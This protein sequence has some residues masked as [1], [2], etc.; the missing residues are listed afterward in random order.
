M[1]FRN[2]VYEGVR[3]VVVDHVGSGSITVEPG[4]RPDLVDCSINAADERFLDEIQV[5][6]DQDYLRITFPPPVGRSTHAHLRLGVPDGLSFVVKAGAADVTIGPAIA[7][8]R[9]VCRSGDITVGC[10]TDLDCST[11]S[12]AI[13]IAR[14]QGSAA[15]IS[16]GSGDVSIGDAFCTTSAKSGSG[17]VVVRSLHSGDLRANSGSGDIAVT[18]T[19]GSVDLRT[20]S[21]SLTVGIADHLPAWLDL[22]SGT[23]DIRIAV[24]SSAPPAPGEPYVSVRGRTGSGDIAVY[25]A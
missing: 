18:S 17:D 13:S 20:A 15:R 19:A 12:G 25:R 21:G 1:S 8:S 7:R 9:I 16:S 10:A 11:G 22:S 6:H 5:R 23:G 2:G 24:P 3:S 4:P 14:V